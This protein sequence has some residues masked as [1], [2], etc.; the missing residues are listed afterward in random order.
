MV[1]RLPVFVAVPSA[2]DDP[3]AIAFRCATHAA[4]GAGAT[5][6]ASAWPRAGLFG[7][8]PD[9]SVAVSVTHA[10]SLVAAVASTLGPVGIDAEPCDRSARAVR[11]IAAPGEEERLF[12]EAARIGLPSQLALWCAKEAVGKALGTGLTNAPR[13]ALFP[14]GTAGLWTLDGPVPLAVR[15]MRCRDSVLAVA[16]PRGKAGQELEIIEL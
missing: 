1:P 7:S 11:R 13:W 15:V 5:A 6:L 8:G 4:A 2:G 14:S 16:F 3:R 9:G 10:S 12:A